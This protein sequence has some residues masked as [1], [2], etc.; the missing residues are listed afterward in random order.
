MTANPASLTQQEWSALSDGF[1]KR[2]EARQAIVASVELRN[3]GTVH[4]FIEPDGRKV[5][6]VQS[7][8]GGHDY[9]GVQEGVQ[10]MIGRNFA[11]LKV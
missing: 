2:K 3:F 11:F 5:T 10:D 8:V 7:L 4:E 9:V 1:A 6:F